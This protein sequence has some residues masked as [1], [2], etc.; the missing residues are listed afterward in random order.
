MSAEDE[1]LRDFKSL[2]SCLAQN[3]TLLKLHIKY[4]DNLSPK[5]HEAIATERAKDHRLV[6]CAVKLLKIKSI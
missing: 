2:T 5:C 4:R 6:F 3:K 1:W